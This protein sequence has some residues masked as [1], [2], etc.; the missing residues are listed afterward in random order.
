MV[1][2]VLSTQLDLLFGQHVATLA[3]CAVYGVAR[4][5]S[6]P[7]SFKRICTALVKHFPMLSQCTFQQV[8][9]CS[10]LD[11]LEVAGQDSRSQ[12]SPS[13]AFHGELRIFYNTKF[14]PRMQSRLLAITPKAPSSSKPSGRGTRLPLKALSAQDINVRQGNA[15]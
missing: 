10:G 13:K 2:A 7:L 6:V 5:Y 9:L 1:Q 14:L 11:E 3:A 8:E 12:H 15:Q 4:A